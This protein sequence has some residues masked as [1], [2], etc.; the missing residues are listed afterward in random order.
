[1]YMRAAVSAD[2]TDSLCGLIL[3]I[4]LFFLKDWEWCPFRRINEVTNDQHE[5]LCSLNR[6]NHDTEGLS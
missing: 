1:M 2:I 5:T 6:D 4:R 3:R